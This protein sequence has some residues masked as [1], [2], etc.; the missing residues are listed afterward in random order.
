[1]H[2]PSQPRPAAARIAQS[3]RS[4]EC[5]LAAGLLCAAAAVSAQAPSN[6]TASAQTIFKYVDTDGRTRFTDRPEAGAVESPAPAQ[7]AQG[8]SGGAV[9]EKAEAVQ[10]IRI[11]NPRPGKVDKKEAARRLQQA[12]RALARRAGA[13][14][15]DPPMTIGSP[16]ERQQAVVE[17]LRRD[18]AAAQARAREVYGPEYSTETTTSAALLAVLDRE[19]L[20]QTR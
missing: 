3:N 4:I 2:L 14:R 20:A 1:M 8:E 17:K 15:G 16:T 19:S 10:V 6:V 9:A 7:A 18:L 13:F 5:L 12:E 11:R